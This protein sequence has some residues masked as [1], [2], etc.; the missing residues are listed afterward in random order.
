[1]RASLLPQACALLAL[2]A[3]AAPTFTTEVKG[4]NRQYDTFIRLY[5]DPQI[6]NQS[7]PFL[8]DQAKKLRTS[9]APG[10]IRLR[11]LNPNLINQIRSVALPNG[12]ALV[13]TVPNVSGS[14][15]DSVLVAAQQACNTAFNAASCSI[16]TAT[17]LG[18]IDT[19]YVF[20]SCDNGLTFTGPLYSRYRWTTGLFPNSTGSVVT[21]TVMSS[22]H[23]ACVASASDPVRTSSAT[24]G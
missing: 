7:D 18:V 2:S 14:S 12:T 22:S 15:P 6:F 9:L 24:S 3:C 4:G 13:D 10:D 8:L 21:R 16:V 20:K 19:L 5:F 11:V 17:A 1:M 23:S